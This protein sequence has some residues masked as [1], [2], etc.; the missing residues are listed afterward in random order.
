MH[1][2]GNYDLNAAAKMIKMVCDQRLPLRGLGEVACDIVGRD[3]HIPP[4]SPMA[5]SYVG[6]GLF[7]KGTSVG[8]G[9]AALQRRKESS[10][11]TNNC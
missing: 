2:A 1:A 9:Q 8:R 5:F 4:R 10:A 3:A 7:P 6:G 11:E